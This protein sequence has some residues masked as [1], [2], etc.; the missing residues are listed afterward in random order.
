MDD[1]KHCRMCYVPLF[2][3]PNNESTSLSKD[4]CATCGDPKNFDLRLQKMILGL[5]CDFHERDKSESWKRTPKQNAALERIIALT[6]EM[7]AILDDRLRLGYL[8]DDLKKR[9]TENSRAFREEHDAMK[10]D[11]AEEEKKRGD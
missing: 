11:R 6:K 4:L 3:D 5:L 1:V 8:T 10:K 9:I 7:G 2:T